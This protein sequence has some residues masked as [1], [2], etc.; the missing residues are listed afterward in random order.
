VLVVADLR[1][2]R[3]VAG[4]VRHKGQQR[5]V[6]VAIVVVIGGQLH[7]GDAGVKKVIHLRQHGGGFLNAEQRKNRAADGRKR[8]A[9][10]QQF[11][12]QPLPLDIG[13]VGGNEVAGDAVKDKRAVVVRGHRLRGVEAEAKAGL[14]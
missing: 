4:A 1:E 8:R 9:A 2:F 7:H 10:L 11:N 13:A 14:G 6:V 3:R 5:A 12:E